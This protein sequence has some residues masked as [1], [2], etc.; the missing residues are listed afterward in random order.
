MYLFLAM[1]LVSLYVDNIPTGVDVAWLRSIFNNHGQVIEAFI[2]VNRVSKYN[3]K[4]GFVRFKTMEEALEAIHA[5][6][7]KIV[8]NFCIHVKIARFS[9]RKAVICG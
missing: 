2:P 1:D 5:L 4:F 6:N 3:T 9:G 7:G 8:Q